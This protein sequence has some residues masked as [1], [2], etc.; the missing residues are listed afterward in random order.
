MELTFTAH[1]NGQHVPLSSILNENL[2]QGGDTRFYA[3][4]SVLV[5]D[6]VTGMKEMSDFSS[7]S[8]SLS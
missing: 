2:I 1:N 3:P 5:P 8:F 7:N 4:D 6:C